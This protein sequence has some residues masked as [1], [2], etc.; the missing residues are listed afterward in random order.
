MTFDAEKQ[1][2]GKK[3]VQIVELTLL[4]C[5]RRCGVAPCT[6]STSGP[7]KCYNTL[8]TCQD[9]PHYV[10]E[11]FVI[12]IANTRVDELQGVNGCPCLPTLLSANCA[13]TEITPTEGLGVRA[14]LSVSLQDHPYNDSGIDYY[15]QERGYDPET[16]GTLWGKLIARYKY[17]ENLK[18]RLFTGFLSAA[19]GSYD[20]S[21][22]RVKGYFLQK[23]LGP[24]ADGKV[25]LTCKDP[26]RWGDKEKAQC[27]L[28]SECELHTDL[29]ETDSIFAVDSIGS[30]PV[31]CEWVRVDTE[32]MKILSRDVGAGTLTVLRASL[33]VWYDADAMVAE[34]HQEG[35]TVQA[36][37]LFDGVRMD[38]IIFTLLNEYTEI[39]SEYLDAIQWA[40]E[41]DVWFATYYFST[42]ITEPTEVTALLEELC[43]HLAIIWWN[44]RTSKITLTAI[45]PASGSLPRLEDDSSIIAD[46]VSIGRDTDARMSQVWIY[47]ALRSP[48][49][50]NEEK[51]FN[52]RFV[53]VAADLDAEL[54]DEYGQPAI[55]QIRSRWLTPLQDALAIEITSRLLSEY[56]DTKVL[57][58]VTVDAK[59]DAIWTAGFVRATTRYRQSVTGDPVSSPYL[60]LSSD[61]SYD[62]GKCSV[63]YNLRESGA[64]AGCS[65]IGPDTLGSYT[66]ESDINKERYSFASN[67]SGFMSNGDIGKK[68]C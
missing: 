34:S 61:E 66:L 21:N 63:V 30:I 23:I 46:S 37:V 28:P 68:I 65:L 19:D 47:Y 15:F 41:A 51:L 44:E 3:P 67:P 39:P 53:K 7:D 57:L 42:L 36:C 8:A 29:N 45:K 33:P 9:V 11:P 60:V 2:V 26:L 58:T 5:S 52:Y 1:Y 59:D 31:S 6:G 54:P 48:V 17:F 64:A 22:F 49:V 10:S 14:S 55:K 35:A 40:A 56:R 18:V 4:R 13:P 62:G 43:Q 12:H 50:E 24:S 20:V 38:S 27:P 16:K 32:V 25:S